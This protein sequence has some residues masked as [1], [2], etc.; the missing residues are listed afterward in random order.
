MSIASSSLITAEQFWQMPDNGPCELVKG[1]IVSVS[2]P[3]WRH[4][5]IA[6]R[7]GQLVENYTSGLDAGVITQR[8]P[9]SVRGADVC[10]HSYARLPAELDPAD[11]PAISPE[12]IWEV[13]SPTDR[14]KKVL[15][16]AHEYL[17]ADVLVVCIVDPERQCFITYYPDR[18]EETLKIGDTWREPTILPGFELPLEKVFRR[19]RN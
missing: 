16:K 10:Y 13:R 8:D 15:G 1:R 19:G 3:G 6:I 2:P 14:W 11:Y 17:E 12:I 9:D 5:R 4:G 7:I 18:P